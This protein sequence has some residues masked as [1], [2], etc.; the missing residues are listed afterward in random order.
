LVNNRNNPQQPLYDIHRFL[1]HFCTFR[2]F[3]YRALA[4][5]EDPQ[6]LDNL[7]VLYISSAKLAEATKIYETLSRKYPEHRDGKVHYVSQLSDIGLNSLRNCVHW[8]IKNYS[9]KQKFFY[10]FQKKKKTNIKRKVFRQK[11][12]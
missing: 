9:F 4:V 3:F 1:S 6:I 5:Q 11:K 12:N 10:F 8:Q 2:L 7:G